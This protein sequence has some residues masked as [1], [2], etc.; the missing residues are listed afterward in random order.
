MTTICILSFAVALIL[1]LLLPGEKQE[2]HPLIGKTYCPIDNSWSLCLSDGRDDYFLAGTQWKPCEIT[3]I[4][5]GPYYKHAPRR[6]RYDPE[7]IEKLF[8]NVEC[9]RGLLHMVLYYERGVGRIPSEIRDYSMSI[10]AY[11]SA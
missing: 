2:T 3:I 7:T 8:I 9:K 4:K 11:P 5:S 1:A 6:Y 10:I